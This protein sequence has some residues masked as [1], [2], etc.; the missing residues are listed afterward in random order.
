MEKQKRYRVIGRTSTRA[1]VDSKSPDYEK[2]VDFHEGRTYS[3]WP[4]HTP[5]E[6][7]VRSGHWVP[8]DEDEK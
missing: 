8:V 4:D 7:W 2:W 5:V 3:R 6:E 1:S